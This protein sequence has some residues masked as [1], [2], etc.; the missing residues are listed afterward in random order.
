MPLSNLPNFSK[1]KFELW[2]RGEKGITNGAQLAKGDKGLYNNNNNKFSGEI[3]ICK[4]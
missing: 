2:F 1:R 3:L 4:L